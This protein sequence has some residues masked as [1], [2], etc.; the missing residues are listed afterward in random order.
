M[1]PVD[2]LRQ[3]HPRVWIDVAFADVGKKAL[4]LHPSI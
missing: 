2:T 3:Y 4:A 1:G